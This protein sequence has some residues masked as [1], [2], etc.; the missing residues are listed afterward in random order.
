L[1][2]LELKMVK[3]DGKMTKFLKSVSAGTVCAVIMVGLAGNGDT[4]SRWM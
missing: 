4:S 3:Q 1:D 2:W